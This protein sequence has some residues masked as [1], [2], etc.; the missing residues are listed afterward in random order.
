[1]IV[2]NV[3]FSL[4]DASPAACQ[5]LVDACHKYLSDHQG[6][7]YFSAGRLAESLDRPVNDR[8]FEVALHVV[9]RSLAD[10]DLYQQHPRHLQFIEEGKP[11]WK[12]VRVFDSQV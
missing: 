3:F 2:H 11:N 7:V 8:Q 6:V 10:H 12:Q 1:M 9:F 5:R 4:H